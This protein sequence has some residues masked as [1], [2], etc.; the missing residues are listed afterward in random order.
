[1]FRKNLLFIAAIALLATAASCTEEK[2][3]PRLSI[4]P[5]INLD[6]TGSSSGFIEVR[7]N[8]RWSAGDNAPWL[9]V[10]P[11]SGK[12]NGTVTVTAEENTSTEERSAR[13]T[14]WTAT[15]R[16]NLT[17]TQPGAAPSIAIDKTAITAGD[18]AGSH[19][20]DVTANAEWT[21]Q[22]NA[23]WLT[24][25]PASGAG[26]GTVTVTIERNTFTEGRTGTVTLRAGLLVK[27]LTVTQA[28]APSLEID[29]TTIS[30]GTGVDSHTLAVTANTAWTAQSNVSWVTLSPASGTGNGTINVTAEANT[31]TEG[32]TATITITIGSLTITVTITQEGVP[33]SPSLE[34]DRT[35]INA[36]ADAATYPLAVTANTA[37]TVRNRTSWLTVR[38]G[39]S[40]GDGTI[41]VTVEANTS[42][43]E[44][45]ATIT[46]TAGN[47]VRTV[48]VTQQGVPFSPSLSTDKTVISAGNGVGSY[49]LSVTANTAWTARSDAPWLT[50]SPD[51]GTGDGKVTVT[52]TTAVNTSTTERTA[53][54][55]I[56]AASLVRTVT[57]TQAA[58]MDP[59]APEL[60]ESM[61]FTTRSVDSFIRFYATAESITVDWGD[62]TTERYNNLDNKKS[63]SHNYTGKAEHTV[64]IRAKGLSSF[65]SDERYLTALD[66]SGC[67]ALTTLYCGGNLLSTLDVSKNTALTYL[68][69][70][71]NQLSALDV[72]KNTALT[73]LYCTGNPL[74]TL[75]VS[76]N[77]ALTVLDC[78]NNQLSTLDVSKNTALSALGCDNNQLSTL[79]VSKNTALTTLECSNNQL[80]ELNVSGCTA[81]T[82]LE[83]FNNQ[84]SAL[85]VSSCTA[86][87]DLRCYYNE[88]STLD[89]SK[90]TALTWLDSNNNQLSALDVSKNAVLEWLDCNTNK[91]SV[92]D[93][94][95]CP[96]ITVLYC[97]SN[98]L[99]VL[100]VS[101]C[102]ALERLECRNNELSANALNNV[103]TN[104]PDRSGQ[105]DGYIFIAGNPGTDTCNRD[106]VKSWSV[107]FN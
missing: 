35:A 31:S 52:V 84:L 1:M 34:I 3:E 47:I 93:L 21:A 53:T 54:I 94:S 18:G 15:L 69:C 95:G 82:T 45:T 7:S 29:K 14:V 74:S 89:M 91:L 59:A 6:A 104:L 42:T 30:T 46:I 8:E 86:L 62:G 20:I 98:E 23:E 102:A 101:G 43:T 99:S 76:K 88:L 25:S 41:W 19:T 60:N 100:N 103:F 33:T 80:S 44:R 57:V 10:T 49:T 79:N 68:S 83:C 67:T 61:E 77:T 40:T 36:E 24:V 70:S 38:T 50:L 39:D 9:T 105:S 85:D 37:W 64:L 16:E 90:N 27:T 72:S 12:G 13:V 75:D 26:D 97:N 107:R 58:A 92:L 51:S 87:T 65:R 73:T 5:E 106:I 56:T 2:P 96:A 32:R 55:T 17:V 71:G 78:S 22:S 81:L 63:V 28:S 48:T 4:D 66:V 11:A